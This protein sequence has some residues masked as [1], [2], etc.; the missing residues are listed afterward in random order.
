M[1]VVSDMLIKL[2]AL[3]DYS[4]LVRTIQESAI[5]IRRALVPEKHIIVQWV[6]KNFNSHWANECEA[7]F[8]RQPVSC[9]IAMSEGRA[10][11]FSCYDVTFKGF[12]GPIGVEQDVRGMEIGKAL[13]MVSL[14]DMIHQGYAY[15]VVGDAG[16]EEFFSNTAGASVIKGSKPGIYKGMLK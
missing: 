13:L 15:A 1:L 10:I 6:L 3:P 11:G 8:C 9:F 5:D 2:Y 16:P 4:A 12:I 14:H 7:A